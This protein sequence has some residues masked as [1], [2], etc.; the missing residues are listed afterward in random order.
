M[1]QPQ[2]RWTSSVPAVRG[3]VEPTTVTLPLRD[4]LWTNPDASWGYDFIDFCAEIGWPLREW[5]RR[6]AI[7]LGE[8]FP[9]GSPRY[10]KAIILIA[11]QN[12]KTLFTRLLISIFLMP[13]LYALVARPEDRLEV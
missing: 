4:D 11:R 13:A 9:N 7:R 2:T 6:L 1:S 5:Q 3:R 12:G 8:L 10:R